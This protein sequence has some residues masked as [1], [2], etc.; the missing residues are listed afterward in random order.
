MDYPA[1]PVYC[2]SGIEW[3][4]KIP[5]H[6]EVRRLKFAVSHND[7]TLPETT[8][9]DY[10]ISYVDISSVNLVD[11]ITHS[12][13]LEFG[14]APSRARRK[15][16][17]QDTIVSTVRTYLKAIAAI[18]NPPENL[19]VSTG[20]AV[21][22]PC[23]NTNGDFLAYYAQSQSFVGAVVA[24]SVGVS[25]PAINASQLVCLSISLPALQEQQTIAQF[26]D[27][28]TQQI[29]QLLAKK[30]TLIDK[31]NEQRIALITHAVTKGLNPA[32]T[33][34][35]SGVEW[36]GE[37]PK[38][39]DVRRAK[40]VSNIF[41]PQRNKPELN[42]DKD[43][44]PWITMEEMGSREISDATRYVSDSAAS[45][46]DSKSLTPNSVIASCVGNFG[47][48]S[49]NRVRV[50]INQ[51]LQAFVPTNISEEYLL[52]IVLI[53]KSYFELIGTAATLVYVNR[54]GFEG[55]PVP[56]PSIEEQWEIVDHL[57]KET[58]RIDRMVEL[59]Q[60]TID[61]LKE[62]RTAL[63]TA[64]VTG[65]IDLRTWQKME[66]KGA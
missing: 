40:F 56:F 52:N 18:K 43:G 33:L 36:L 45:E 20:F 9:P 25:Y 26:L 32:V 49:I 21:L 50:I 30:Q 51:Q 2:E 17:D 66:T 39:W 62:Y 6:W 59:N 46:A 60:Q 34:E 3:L 14:K 65:K 10:L 8:E 23:E 11:G 35:D 57:D 31:L 63:I 54:L 15:V 37:I 1:Y 61:K 27:H 7:E 47:V 29:D 5:D 64:A 13:D 41:I 4:G 55:M 16:K 44:L 48:A 38:H 42:L 19:I 12:E 22:R 24:H 28:K 58:A 53:S